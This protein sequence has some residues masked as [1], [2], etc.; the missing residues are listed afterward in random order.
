MLLIVIQ[1]YCRVARIMC[2]LFSKNFQYPQNRYKKGSVEEK[3]STIFNNIRFSLLEY[4]IAYVF[5]FIPVI[6]IFKLK[7]QHFLYFPLILHKSR[8]KLQT[9]KNKF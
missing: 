1:L 5:H 9:R 7:P 3:S 2:N 4:N 6:R 8:L